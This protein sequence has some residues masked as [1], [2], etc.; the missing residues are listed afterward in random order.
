MSG[1]VKKGYVDTRINEKHCLERLP[2]GLLQITS[3]SKWLPGGVLFMKTGEE[4][5]LDIPGMGKI[6]VFKK[7]WR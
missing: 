3:D 5:T 6:T 4:Y 1:D 2:G 7:T